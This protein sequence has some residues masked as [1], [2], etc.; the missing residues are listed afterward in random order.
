MQT[1]FTPFS[2]EIYFSD[3]NKLS[4]HE[5]IREFITELYSKSPVQKNGNF[6]GTGL[7][8]YFYDDFT[9]HLDTLPQFSEL[10]ELILDKSKDYIINRSKNIEKNG[11]PNSK[12]ILD[13]IIDVGLELTTLWF[14]VNPYGGYQGRHHHAMNL[15]GGTYYL[16]TPNNSGKIGFSDPNPFSYYKSQTAYH[17][18]LLLSDFTASTN[19]G[20]MLIWPGWMDH[21]ISANRNENENRMTLSWG[22]NWSN[23][24]QDI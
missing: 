8:T 7:T 21:E 24:A 12:I 16:Q 13:K 9:S 18:H 10:K 20:D 15:L 23:H 1:F 2:S 6:Y 3:E 14:N 22:V 11:G 5:E 19:E 4:N 17:N